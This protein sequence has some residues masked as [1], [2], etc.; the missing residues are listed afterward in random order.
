MVKFDVGKFGDSNNFRL[1]NI[2]M[3]AL[4][5]L[6]GYEG[7]LDGEVTLALTLRDAKRRYIM[8]KTLDMIKLSLL[9]KLL[10]E[11]YN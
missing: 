1:W 5:V 2:K 10:R 11:V 3:K 8:A 6:H 7:T 4:L 9:D